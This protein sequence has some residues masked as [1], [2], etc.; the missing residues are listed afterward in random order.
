MAF[1]KEHSDGKTPLVL[2]EVH[3]FGMIM[4]LV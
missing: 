4:A 3:R 1:T 2:H